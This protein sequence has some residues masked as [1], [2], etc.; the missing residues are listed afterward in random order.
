MRRIPKLDAYGVGLAARCVEEDAGHLCMDGD[1]EVWPG[2]DVPGQI[3]RFGGDTFSFLI[4]ICHF[5]K[6]V[7][8]GKE[9]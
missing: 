1:L 7:R 2:Q 9:N 8:E 5:C 6:L 3:C 4:Y